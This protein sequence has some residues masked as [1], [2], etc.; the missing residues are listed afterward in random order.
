MLR[1][2]KIDMPEI[3][4]LGLTKQELVSLQVNTDDSPS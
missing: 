2:P 3:G 4:M 1:E